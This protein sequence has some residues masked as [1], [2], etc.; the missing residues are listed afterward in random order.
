MSATTVRVSIR[1]LTGSGGAIVMGALM[2]SAIAAQERGYHEQVKL[3]QEVAAQKAEAEVQEALLQAAR[4]SATNPRLAIDRLQQTLAQVQANPALPDQR[5][6]GMARLLRDR[7][8][9]LEL[10]QPAATVARPAGP[11]VATPASRPTVAPANTEEQYLQSTLAQ[12]RALE[13]QGRTAEAQRLADDLARRFPDNPAI[14]ASI[15]MSSV[16]SKIGSA[17]TITADHDSRALATLNDI[18]RSARPPAGDIEFDKVITERAAKRVTGVALTAKEKAILHGLNKLVSVKFDNTRFQD[19][20]EYIATELDQP[21][22]LDKQALNDAQIDYDTLVSAQVRDISL[23]TLLRKVLGEFGLTYVVRGE[24]IQVVSIFKAQDLMVTRAYYI[25]DLV[26]DGG[27]N[28][29]GLNPLYF[30]NLDQ[31]AQAQRAAAIIEMIQTTVD[32]DSWRLNGGKAAISFD[33]T[34]KSLIIRQS[35]EVHAILGSGMGR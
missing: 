32:P 28:A 3:L 20:I 31:L 34:T 14:Q 22:I 11:P 5:K 35:A 12:V 4:L 2:V 13:Q 33:F 6:E 17:R 8:R 21:V 24:A 15:R 25:G 27:A 26:S 16:A 29:F 30:T 10:A 9:R 23:R 18:N 19:V 1:W 7:I